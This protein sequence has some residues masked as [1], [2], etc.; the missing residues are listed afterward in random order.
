MSKYLCPIVWILLCLSALFISFRRQVSRS[1][2]A[3]RQWA[4]DN[5]YTLVLLK[6]RLFALGPFFMVLSYHNVYIVVIEDKEGQRRS[7]WLRTGG[8]V[9]NRVDVRWDGDIQ[10]SLN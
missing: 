10:E 7:G 4:V 1:T 5:D 8:Y 3:I 6:R 2:A 9:S